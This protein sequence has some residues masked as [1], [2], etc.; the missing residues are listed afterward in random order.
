MLQSSVRV[1]V[2]AAGFGLAA[3]GQADLLAYYPFDDGT[4][5]D[6]S[7]NNR[8][9]ALSAIAPEYL[10]AGG[11][12]GG[13]YRF[14]G[15]TGGQFN[16]ID[17]PVDVSTSTSPVITMGLWVKA[18]S[19]W[20]TGTYKGANFRPLVGQILSSDDG[21]FDRTL[22]NDWRAGETASGYPWQIGAFAGN[23]GVVGTGSSGGGSYQFLTMRHNQL[24]GEFS[25]SLGS[26]G[27]LV[28]FDRSGVFY[29]SS[30]RNFLRVGDSA[31]NNVW[32]ERFHGLVDN[33]F[34]Y[35]EW[36]SDDRLAEIYASNG[37]SVVPEPAT[38]TAL[39]FGALVATRRRRK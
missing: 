6:V 35:D 10:A 31:T 16:H 5:Q 24:T 3:L 27:S 30:S 14:R 8:H 18:E 38:M 33:V 22:T 11:V 9:G 34:V 17:L 4:A 7:G 12:T 36:V 21:G 2:V 28:N 19:N 29:D 23:N 26:G 20:F 37:A 32:D 13:A 1:F 25:L 39:A 15:F